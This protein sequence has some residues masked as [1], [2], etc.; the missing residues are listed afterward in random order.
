[1]ALIM[2]SVTFH[3]IMWKHLKGEYLVFLIKLGVRCSLHQLFAGGPTPLI[4]GRFHL[5]QGQF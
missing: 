3:V 1:M 4:S 2:L 5:P